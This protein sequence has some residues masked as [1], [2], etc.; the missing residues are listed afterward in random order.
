MLSFKEFISEGKRS[1]PGWVRMTVFAIV[2][3]IRSL[4]KRIESE[5]DPVEQNKMISQQNSL[6]SFINGLG[7]GVGTNDNQLITKMRSGIGSIKR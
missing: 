5:S 7:I 6:I 1:Y 4:Q 2:V 3:K